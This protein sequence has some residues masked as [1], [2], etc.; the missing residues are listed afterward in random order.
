MD[1]YMEMK[2]E[3]QKRKLFLIVECQLT[4]IQEIMERKPPLG[5]HHRKLIQIRKMKRS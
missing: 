4:N 2:N 3:R 5:H 1:I